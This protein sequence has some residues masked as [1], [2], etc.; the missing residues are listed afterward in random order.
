MILSRESTSA[1]K[2]YKNFKETSVIKPGFS[3]EGIYGGAL[4]G[5]KG[6]DFVAFHDWSGAVR[7]SVCL[8]P[9]APPVRLS[10]EPPAIAP[11]HMVH[12]AA[13]VLRSV[14]QPPNRQCRIGYSVPIWQPLIGSLQRPPN[15]QCR[16][17]YC[18]P[19]WQPLIGFGSGL[20]TSNAE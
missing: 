13:H 9:S 15:R 16:I 1:V 4:L 8:C 18:S 19:I 2:I 14:Q 10:E 12:R 7:R 11:F 17:G 6:S 5:I 3:A 20:Q